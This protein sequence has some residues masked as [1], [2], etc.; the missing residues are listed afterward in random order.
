[1]YY[2][3]IVYCIIIKLHCSTLS[4]INVLIKLHCS[5]LSAIIGEWLSLYRCKLFV[6]IRGGW[7]W[8]YQ[9][10]KGIYFNSKLLLISTYKNEHVKFKKCNTKVWNSDQQVS[11]H[12]KHP[13]HVSHSA[14][15]LFQLKTATY[16]HLQKLTCKIQ[17][18]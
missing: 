7:G 17:K 13:K 10:C 11:K 1:M 16:Q 9:L 8:A 5:T 3:I 12:P 6:I 2:C 15:H 4:A 18:M 14:R